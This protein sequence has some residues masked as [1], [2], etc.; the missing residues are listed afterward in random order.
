MNNIPQFVD[1]CTQGVE[2]DIAVR[3]LVLSSVAPPRPTKYHFHTNLSDHEVFQAYGA[4]S[5]V[6]FASPFFAREYAISFCSRF[7]QYLRVLV[8]V[9]SI[10]NSPK[11]FHYLSRKREWDSSDFLRYESSELYSSVLGCVRGYNAAL[12][13]FWFNESPSSNLRILQSFFDVGLTSPESKHDL[14]EY[15]NYLMK[16]SSEHFTNCTSN[17][18]YETY[19]HNI[20]NVGRIRH[21]LPDHENAKAEAIKRV[22]SSGFITDY[23]YVCELRGLNKKK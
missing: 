23:N 20:N 8:E 12:L 9:D 11:E 22:G 6:D 3:N 17:Y 18:L 13:C 1:F 14:V 7:E 15:F 16:G 21:L 2:T 10:D 5:L 19:R 4:K